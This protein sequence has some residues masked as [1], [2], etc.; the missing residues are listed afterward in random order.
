MSNGSEDANTADRELLELAAKAAGIALGDFEPE[1]EYSGIPCGAFELDE[2][3]LWNPLA[4]DGDALCLAIK[5]KLDVIHDEESEQVDVWPANPS[6]RV[7]TEKYG[8]DEFA[9]TRR[10]IVCAAAEIGRT[11]P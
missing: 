5:L 7:K 6:T 10:A 4:A 3:T 2:E 9:A 8:D 1:A 11:K